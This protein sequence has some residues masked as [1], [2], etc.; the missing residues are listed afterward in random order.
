MQPVES[1]PDAEESTETVF[2]VLAGQA[3]SHS[4]AH[5][6]ITAIVGAVDA[7]WIF[8]VYPSLWWLASAFA[9]GG[10]YGLWGITDRAIADGRGGRWSRVLR[11]ARAGLALGGVIAAAAALYGLMDA[12]AFRGWKH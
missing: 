11:V 5:L 7:A 12:A 2:T 10:A 1:K 9:A 8:A 6:W 3:R 4:R